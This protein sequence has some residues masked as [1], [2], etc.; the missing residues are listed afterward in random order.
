MAEGGSHPAGSGERTIALVGLRCS[1]KTSVGR[2][3]AAALD[4]LFVDL[5]DVTFAT[6]RREELNVASVGELLARVGEESFRRIE[7]EALDDVLDKL[8]PCVLATGGGVVETPR[9]RAR[10]ANKA[11]TIWLVADLEELGR[12]LRADPASRP[13]LTGADPADELAVL[14]KRRAP[15]YREVSMW[16]IDCGERGVEEITEE[17]RSRLEESS[18]P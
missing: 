7:A 17:I 12:R 13:S 10:L 4:R 3:L 11:L 16:R 15:M 18:T 2:R 5:D 9:A 14:L 6:G 1:G 8:P